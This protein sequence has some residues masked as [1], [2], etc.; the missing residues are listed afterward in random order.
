M[1]G[2][3]T[4]QLAMNGP[5]TAAAHDYKHLGSFFM[6][7]FMGNISSTNIILNP[8]LI[9]GFKFAFSTFLLSILD[10]SSFKPHPTSITC[11]LFVFVLDIS[12]FGDFSSMRFLSLSVSTFFQ[13]GTLFITEKL[14]L[15]P[16]RRV[17]WKQRL[18]VLG[19]CKEGI[20]FIE[21]F[22]SAYV[23]QSN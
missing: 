7:D 8:I 15:F 13:L 17:I 3:A 12:S 5:A 20:S 14:E 10:D 21:N 11:S 22:F 16:Q 2:P 9:T 23:R 4:A 18:C 19:C 1:N 6:I